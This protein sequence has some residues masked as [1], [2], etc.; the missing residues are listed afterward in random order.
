MREWKKRWSVGRWAPDFVLPS[1]EGVPTRFYGKAG[2]VP[3]VLLFCAG[4]LSE[5]QWDEVEVLLHQRTD[6]NSTALAHFVFTHESPEANLEIA[7]SHKLECTLFSDNQQEFFSL[8]E[9]ETSSIQVVIL[10]SSMRILD[11]FLWESTNQTY[12]HVVEVLSSQ[13]P[14]T[15][16]TIDTQAP[17]LL[18]P[19]VLEE[20]AC[21]HLID[22][23]HQK[24]HHQTGVERSEKGGRIELLDD[25]FKRRQD[26]IVTDPGLLRMLTT[27][28]GHCVIPQLQKVFSF[29]AT[30]FEGF[31]IVCYDASQQGYFRPHR[32]NLS[33][34]TQ[35]RKFALSLNLNEGYQGGQLRFAEYAPHL[36]QPGRGSAIIFSGA[37]LHEV[38]DV[39]EGQRFTLLSFLS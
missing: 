34:A 25:A 36:Y 37:M 35:H 3:A 10:A 31:K 13:P 27:S 38:L 39:T 1:Q 5:N 33:P 7:S 2:G 6:K 24:G 9:G 30:R 22:V 19:Q 23:W 26:H 21:H 12:E 16:V 4:T 20:A 15:P 28:I 17:V 32:D 29:R 18:L 14:I 11:V 8:P